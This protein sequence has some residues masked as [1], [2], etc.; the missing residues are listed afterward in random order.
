MGSEAEAGARWS[1]PPRL[2][3]KSCYGD[4]LWGEGE[5]GPGREDRR[6]RLGGE[7]GSWEGEREEGE[8]GTKEIR[9]KG[10][11]SFRCPLFCIP[12]AILPSLIGA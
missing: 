5:E 2:Q 9:L 4:R 3:W 10:E 11:T 6:R 7:E 12:P 8:G 1:H